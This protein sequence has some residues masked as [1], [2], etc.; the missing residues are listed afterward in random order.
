MA[1]GDVE[2]G[3]SQP[4][5]AVSEPPPLQEMKAESLKE[6]AVASVAGVGCT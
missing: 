4:L 1:K 5:L 6:K 3:E 2:T